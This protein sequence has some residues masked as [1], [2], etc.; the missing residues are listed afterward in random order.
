MHIKEILY[1]I[2]KKRKL[3]FNDQLFERDHNDII[4]EL[5]RIILSCE[6]Y[7]GYKIHVR[8]F[9]VIED[10]EMIKNLQAAHYDS[11]NRTKKKYIKENIYEA[12]N[13]ND[14]DVVILL[15]SYY[16]EDFRGNYTTLTTMIYVPVY[17]DKY[18]FNIG[19]VKYSPLLQ[20]SDGVSYNIKDKKN[21]KMLITKAVFGAIT[22]MEN[23]KYNSLSTIYGEV[24]DCTIY[25]VNMFKKFN[26]TVVYLLAK[27]GL[28]GALQF[29]E[30]QHIHFSY[31]EPT[32]FNDQYYTFMCG[33]SI[34]I[35]VPK[36]LYENDHI[37]QCFIGTIVVEVSGKVTLP[38]IENTEYWAK[39]IAKI[40]NYD[41]I[42]KGYTTLQSIEMLFD[43]GTQ[44]YIHLPYEDKQSIYHIM[45]WMMREFNTLVLKSNYSLKGK[46]I[47]LAEY[48]ASI[49]ANKLSTSLFRINDNSKKTDV[50]KIVQVLNIEPTY[51][52]SYIS[53]TSIVDDM[54]LPNDN[55]G[56]LGIKYSFKGPAGLGGENVNPNSFMKKKGKKNKGSN[57]PTKCRHIDLSHIG[58]LDLYSSPKSDPG[59]GGLLCPTTEVYEDNYLYEHTE[60]NKWRENY[61]E[62][63]G[64]L[65]GIKRQTELFQIKDKLLSPNMTK[66][67]MNEKGEFV[68]KDHTIKR[69]TLFEFKD[70]INTEDV[71]A[72]AY[73]IS[74]KL[75][76]SEI[77]NNFWG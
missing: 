50:A 6:R 32:V 56:K 2:S 37:T 5:K 38:D 77:N 28:Y 64:K 55:D 61:I 52:I 65:E 20:I 71:Y 29:L 69:K 13:L 36:L 76:T 18:Y 21:N 68:M 73:G 12:I 3:Q 51:L 10:Y 54:D 16:I 27:Y 40:F 11:I 34:Y 60:P 4:N 59:L 1:N 67:V 62:I 53:R 30:L 72:N 44:E 22:M 35:S 49:Y 26:N 19:G 63:L 9:Q 17:L 47:R 66:T 25:S 58:K 74:I 23:P 43:K 14:S 42:S 46:R 31:T 39:K 70:D 15:V 41:N 33:S 75:D 24:V 57:I 45:R 7:A 48:L 8:G